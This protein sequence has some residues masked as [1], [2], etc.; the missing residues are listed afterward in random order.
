MFILRISLSLC[1]H[2]AVIH[3]IYMAYGKLLVD[4]CNI[5]CSKHIT[6]HKFTLFWR[7]I[8]FRSVWE[9]MGCLICNLFD[10]YFTRSSLEAFS[11]KSFGK[12]VFIS[13][14]WNKIY[15][16]DKLLMVMHLQRLPLNFHFLCCVYLL[17]NCIGKNTVVGLSGKKMFDSR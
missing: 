13:H 11:D 6:W 16:F 1:F 17:Y 8:S 12:I 4:V 7:Q 9:K 14:A 2:F 10:V 5:W 3:I 15:N